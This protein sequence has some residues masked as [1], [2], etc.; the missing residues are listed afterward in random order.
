MARRCK[1]C[2]YYSLKTFTCDYMLRRYE[3]RGCPIDGCTRYEPSHLADRLGDYYVT[4]EGLPD[5]QVEFLRLYE[6]GLTDYEI[7]GMIGRPRST[8]TM[9]RVKMGLPSQ[10]QLRR[11][12]CGDDAGD[13]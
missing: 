10:K 12:E 3:R 5:A 7:A 9:W 1:T 2:K 4:G 13:Y 8:I 6:A 11:E